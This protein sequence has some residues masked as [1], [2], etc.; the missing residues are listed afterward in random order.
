[1]L[2]SGSVAVVET[3]GRLVGEAS[4]ANRLESV[5][6]ELTLGLA[7]VVGLGSVVVKAT[8]ELVKAVAVGLGEWSVERSM[9]ESRQ[10]LACWRMAAVDEGELC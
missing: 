9:M 4:A 1:M 7:L 3:G 2:Q 5:A 8:L 6:T 10:L